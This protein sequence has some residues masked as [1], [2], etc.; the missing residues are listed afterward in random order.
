MAAWVLAC[1]SIAVGLM[2]IESKA[3]ISADGG[4]SAPAEC[5]R[6]QLAGCLDVIL[7]LMFLFALVVA[8][9]LPVVVWD[10]GEFRGQTARMLAGWVEHNRYVCLL[11]AALVYVA[12]V[13]GLSRGPS[14]GQWALGISIVRRSTDVPITRLRAAG[15]AV[16]A[17]L[18][19]WP[20]RALDALLPARFAR[21][22]SLHDQ[23]CDT[24]VILRQ[25]RGH[26]GRLLLV[27]AIA[28]VVL[29]VTCYG[30]LFVVYRAWLA[31][32]NP[33]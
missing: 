19:G 7:L 33:A 13:A 30:A 27:A 23:W 15:R 25:P 4:L 22:Q 2:G 8:L 1:S 31:V 29:A 16:L 11:M 3:G 24:L 5:W 18:I 14:L 10:P 28:V 26:A 9:L 32:A 20:L 6:W 17:L 21:R 12:G